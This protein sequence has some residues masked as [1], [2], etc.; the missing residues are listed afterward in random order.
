MSDPT[1]LRCPSCSHKPLRS[2]EHRLVCDAC[3]GMLMPTDDFAVA[4]RE[5]DPS[6]GPL[7]FADPRDAG[8]P[9]PRCRRAMSSSAVSIGALALPER[10]LRCEQDGLWVS[11]SCLAAVFARLSR[12][13][14]I[15]GGAGPS[16]DPGVYAP[17]TSGGLAAAM[18]SIHEAFTAGTPASAGLAI[19]RWHRTRPSVH[20]LFVSAYKDRQLACPS[21]KEAVLDYRGERWACDTCRGSFVEN[22]ALAA[23]VA[24]MINC[25]WE[26]PPTAGKPGERGCPVCGAAMR[27]ELLEAV[28]IDRCAAHGVWFDDHELEDTLHHA[29][30]GSPT[31]IS[32]WLRRLFHRPGKLEDKRGP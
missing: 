11:Q 19:S 16:H 27:V 17:V 1:A 14:R 4:I 31:G 32:G 26:L 20:T 5:I 18:S 29:G 15:G 9:C 12:H 2:F 3:H 10:M 21:C 25:P 22:A 28:T 8:K 30:T 23:M 7:G 13:V 6:R 24:E